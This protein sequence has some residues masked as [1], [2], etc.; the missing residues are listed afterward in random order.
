MTLIAAVLGGLVCGY[1][2]GF[3]VKSLAV[4]LSFWLVVLIVQTTVVLDREDVPPDAW[5]YVPV[6]VV[7]LALGI[8][9][10][11]VAAKAR[12]RFNRRAKAV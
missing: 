5:E 9:L 6:Q 12:A 7:I 11:W 10:I 8:G 1:M 2:M 4:F 3:R